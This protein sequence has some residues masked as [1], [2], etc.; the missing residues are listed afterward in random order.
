[1]RVQRTTYLILEAFPVDLR[2]DLYVIPS[3]NN[4]LHGLLGCESVGFIR[5]GESSSPIERLRC[6]VSG[7]QGRKVP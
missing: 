4:S 6:A 7:G 3:G 1:M 5:G 2:C